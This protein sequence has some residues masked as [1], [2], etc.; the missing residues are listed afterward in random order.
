MP[1]SVAVA[2]VIRYSSSLKGKIL[3]WD[4][5][6]I[7][8]YSGVKS[9]RMKAL[10]GQLVRQLNVLLFVSE[11]GPNDGGVDI[12]SS[13]CTQVNDIP[14]V[15]QCKNWDDQIGPHV[16]RELRGVVCEERS[17]TVGIL[18]G[19]YVEIFSDAAVEAAEIDELR[20]KFAEAEAENIKLKQS[21]EE[22]ALKDRVTKLEQNQT[23]SDNKNQIDKLDDDIG[24]IK[25]IS[26]LIPQEQSSANIT[27]FCE[28]NSEDNPKQIDSRYTSASDITDNT[29][30]SDAFSDI[31]ENVSDN[32]SN[33]IS[34]NI[35]NKIRERN[36]EKNLQSQGSMQNT[37][38]FSEIQIS[39]ITAQ[40]IADLFITAIKV[41]QKEMQS[42][43][44]S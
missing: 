6:E 15:F 16:V 36:R 11:K 23:Q 41:R 1:E 18:V 29:S 31:S 43:L 2:V 9:N 34:E 13:I 3:E 32:V 21:L 19:P 4:V 8:K 35:S 44:I 24:K 39:K 26:T 37:S 40:N 28:T 12:R 27:S 42:V 17:G 14:L 5:I 30:N 10:R 7:L 38:S 20:K 25:Q 22:Y 33:L